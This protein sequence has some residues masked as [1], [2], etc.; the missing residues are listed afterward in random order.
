M[1]RALGTLLVLVA[2]VWSAAAGM[3]SVGIMYEGWH[4]PAV[5]AIEDCDGCARPALTIEAVLRSNGTLSLADAYARRNGSIAA[6]FQFH[7]EPLDGFYCMYRKRASDAHGATGLRDC[8]NISATAARH[9]QMLTS[10]GIDFVVVDSTNIQSDSEFGDAIQLRPFEVLAEEWHALRLRGESTPQIAI[11]QNLQDPNGTLWKRFVDARSVYANASYGDTGS[12]LLLR[13]GRTG[14]PAFF[15]TAKPDETLVAVLED[16]HGPY[17]V[18]TQVMWALRD[19]YDAGEMAFMSPCI[20][21][22]TGAFT[23][24]VPLENTPGNCSQKMTRNAK[25]GPRGTALTVG[26][27]YQLSYSSL[28]WLA[29]G[30]LGGT[31]LQAQF[32]AAFALRDELDYLLI[33]TFNEHIAQPQPNPY[34]EHN[35]NAIS[36]GFGDSAP[37]AKPDADAGQLWVDMFGDAVTRDVE[38]TVSDGGAIWRLLRSCLR[39]L[40]A[41]DGC[42]DGSNSSAPAEACCDV[43]SPA[44]RWKA[45]WALEL[46]GSATTDL[47]LTVD[48]NERQELLASGDWREVCSP[49][50]GPSAFC[51]GTASDV[52]AQYTRGPFLLYAVAQAP[53]AATSSPV[54]RC[55][56]AG[57]DEK[58]ASGQYHFVSGDASCY[59]RGKQ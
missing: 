54:Y 57:D 19:N 43:Q 14:R 49:F 39:V 28:P 46:S 29:S 2:S 37:D 12:D 35:P 17:N 50:G 41:G 51:D 8:R 6:G 47:L 23:S 58:V 34:A 1:R 42:A 26:P 3:P 30:K 53:P 44:R 40:A 15:T 7:K 18:T 33:G 25:L 56:S 24:S 27:S 20:N 16:A 5:Q 4:A 55:F 52:V 9:A 59:G 13:D 31:T 32:R 38:P 22:A 45:V 36:L 21:A 48:R 10:A 11:W